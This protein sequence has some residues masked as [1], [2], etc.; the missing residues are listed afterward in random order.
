MI[1]Y[2]F[3]QSKKL[4]LRSNWSTRRN[5]ISAE[6]KSFLKVLVSVCFALWLSFVESWFGKYDSSM[7]KNAL[8]I[9]VQEIRKKMLFGDIQNA[10]IKCSP[11]SPLCC[12]TVSEN[13][14]FVL[15]DSIM[16]KFE[17]GTKSNVLTLHQTI[18]WFDTV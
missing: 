14:V 4:A 10:R 12:L 1:Y 17:K 16:I 5:I 2:S 6:S 3:I 13:Y 9:Y 11:V 7:I 15:C 8:Y 18:A